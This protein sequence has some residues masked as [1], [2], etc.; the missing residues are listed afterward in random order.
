MHWGTY[1]ANICRYGAE[2]TSFSTP[3]VTYNWMKSL[4]S[5]VLKT[6]GKDWDN[7]MN[8][9]LPKIR[10]PMM[11]GFSQIWKEYLDQLQ[12][13]ISNKVPALEVS[14]NSMRPIL[15]TS[16]RSTENQ[17]RKTIEELSQ[18]ASSVAFDSAEF[19]TDE[20]KPTFEECMEIDGRDSYRRRRAII[21]GKVEQDVKLM[22]EEMLNRLADGLAEKKAEVPGE[23]IRI[24]DE[25]ING[26][27][28]QLSF[29][30]NNLVENSADGSKINVQKTELQT[31]IRELVEAWE[32]AWAEEGDYP[33]HIL[34]QDLSIP[35]DIPAPILDEENQGNMGL[36]MLDD[37]DFEDAV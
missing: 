10:K 12:Q 19:L 3:R 22:C 1:Y 4:A 6:L 36:D 27:K 18:K 31:K 11:A 24:A 28:Q 21:N 35:E 30:V 17:I 23:L 9:K 8:K 16:Q 5:P 37:E 34:D 13:D 32:D 15:N 33:E 14:F 20:M 2:Y 29:L 26:V 7:K 25:A